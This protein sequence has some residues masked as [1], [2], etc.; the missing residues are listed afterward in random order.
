MSGLDQVPEAIL[1]LLAYLFE[2]PSL[3]TTIGEVLRQ[4]MASDNEGFGE[5]W[6]R[7]I[8]GRIPV[9]TKEGFPAA[10][11]RNPAATPARSARARKMVLLADIQFENDR[12]WQALKAYS[13]RPSALPTSRD[14]C[15]H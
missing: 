1:P 5:H 2:T 12:W 10:V 9:P 13:T 8:A 3:P 7:L 6:K 15:G 11:R 14:D 4:G